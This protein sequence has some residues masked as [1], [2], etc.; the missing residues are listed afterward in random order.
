MAN[1]FLFAWCRPT[2]FQ[3]FI[4]YFDFVNLSFI[5]WAS[6]ECV[7][8]LTFY[9]KLVLIVLVPPVALFVVAAVPVIILWVQNRLDMDDSPHRRN[10]RQLTRR[11]IIRLVVFAL[12]LMYPAISSRVISFFICQNVNGTNFLV[13]DFS[14]RC[15]D[16]TW[17]KWLPLAISA[18]IA[19]PVILFPSFF[20]LSD[21][22]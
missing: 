18:V 17:L 21:P 2:Y 3:T 8:T 22:F 7:T 4:N 16:D 15:G 5:P 19:Y 10:Q 6:L 9:D 14:A 1:A 11:K 12:F 13:A 20:V